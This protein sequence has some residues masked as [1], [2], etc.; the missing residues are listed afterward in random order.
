MPESDAAAPP[1]E[2]SLPDY[3]GEFVGQFLA[4]PRRVNQEMAYE[5]LREFY[6]WTAENLP[7]AR[8]YS[9]AQV[10]QIDRWRRAA[11]E[12]QAGE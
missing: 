1:G 2:P 8:E 4:D 7:A 10:E 3:L 12:E 9:Q 6:L 5:F 11:V